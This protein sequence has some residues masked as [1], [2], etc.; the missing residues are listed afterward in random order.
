MSVLFIIIA[1]LVAQLFLQ[2]TDE[3]DLHS[4]I[5]GD[6]NRVLTAARVRYRLQPLS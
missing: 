4:Q 1:G 3:G 5:A 6:I 2:I